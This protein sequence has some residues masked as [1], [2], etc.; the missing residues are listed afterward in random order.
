MKNIA[1]F[2]CGMAELEYSSNSPNMYSNLYFMAT[3]QQIGIKFRYNDFC[4]EQ[5]DNNMKNL[6]F[7]FSKCQLHPQA[8][9]Q[10]HNIII[11]ISGFVLASRRQGMQSHSSK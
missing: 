1:T 7:T 9:S 10:S 2:L 4:N 5:N 11:Y 8:L 3:K 6:N